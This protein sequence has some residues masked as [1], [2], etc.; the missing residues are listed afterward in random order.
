[1]WQLSCTLHWDTSPETGALAS[2]D[3]WSFGMTHD[4]FSPGRLLSQAGPGR[5]AVRKHRE[6]S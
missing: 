4:A 6:T 3:L 5:L 2:G 1:M